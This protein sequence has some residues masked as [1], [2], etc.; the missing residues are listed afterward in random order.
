MSA[1]ESQLYQGLVAMGLMRDPRF[2]MM[3]RPRPRDPVFVVN[4]RITVQVK[5]STRRAPGPWQFTFSLGELEA[6]RARQQGNQLHVFVLVC[7]T[8][9]IAVIG[10]ED[11]EY[12]LD[13]SDTA[14]Q[15]WL[16]V[17]DRP[18]SGLR[19]TAVGGARSR[20]IARSHFPRVIYDIAQQER[21][22]SGGGSPGAE[23]A[24]ERSVAAACHDDE[25]GDLAATSSPK[26]LIVKEKS[27][28]VDAAGG[29]RAGAG[30]L[31]S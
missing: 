15:Q 18:G 17:D 11:L 29:P 5:Y 19:V 31:L 24:S 7:H 21:W 9:V 30:S 14:R 22:A 10:P 3:R 26:P 16:R 8:E 6:I 2:D 28:A 27:G 12:L 13:L 20:K 1:L 23:P 25:D 4:D